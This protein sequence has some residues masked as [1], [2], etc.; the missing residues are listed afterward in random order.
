M[1]FAWLQ[2]H[3]DIDPR[4]SALDVLIFAAYNIA[5]WL[6]LVLTIV[7]AIDTDTGFVAFAGIVAVRAFFNLIRNNFLPLEQ[8]ITF[9]FR[10]P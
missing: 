5:Y 9:P 10:A 8:A 2:K 3:Q 1:R 6:P 7:G 4:Q